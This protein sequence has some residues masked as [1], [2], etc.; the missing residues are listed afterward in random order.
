MRSWLI[1]NREKAIIHIAKQQLQMTEGEYRKA[2]SEVGV[3]SSKNLTFP[4]YEKFLQRLKADGF[5]LESQQKGVYGQH[6]QTWDKEPLLE[7][8][9]ALLAVMKLTWNYAD[10]I[11][12]RMFKVDSVLWCGPDQLHSVVA[13]LEY[14]RRRM[15]LN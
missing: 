7:K 1:G 5:V 12:R 6:P 8:I 13:A 3:A 9:G 4:Q 11:A 10:G 14:K 2:L 15:Q